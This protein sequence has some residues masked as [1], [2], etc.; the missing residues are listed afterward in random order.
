MSTA[1]DSAFGYI[2][3]PTLYKPPP[4]T[5]KEQIQK[6]RTAI[7]TAVGTASPVMEDL[8]QPEETSAAE[9]ARFKEDV[10]EQNLR[11]QQLRSF[12]GQRRS[13]LNPAPR[14]AYYG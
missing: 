8:P 3:T 13:L 1:V 10:E 11:R 7:E 12:R 2:S 4:P 14:R 5:R 9:Q 6:K